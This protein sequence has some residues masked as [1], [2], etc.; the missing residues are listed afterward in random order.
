MEKHE[1]ATTNPRLKDQVG[2]RR[3]ILLVSPVRD[4]LTEYTAGLLADPPDLGAPTVL[5]RPEHPVTYDEQLSQLSIDPSSTEVVLI[6][7]GHG[8]AY[9][10]DV[11][12]GS[13]DTPFFDQRDVLAGPR[14]LLAFCSNA[15]AELGA[16]YERQTRGRT[17]VGFDSE[18]GFV[19]A[20]GEYASTWRK[21]MFGITLAMLSATDRVTL[22]KSVI[23]LYKDALSFFSSE[24]GRKHRWWLAMSMYLRQQMQAVSCIRT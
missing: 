11:P 1:T 19:M 24:Q 9:S 20:G 4:K 13:A 17:F 18:I 3:V 5:C 7:C 14:F 15:G 12:G 22:E 6:F 16:A 8:R 23:G 2:E 10:L 21:I